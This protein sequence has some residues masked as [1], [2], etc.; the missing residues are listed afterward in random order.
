MR[1]LGLSL[2]IALALS[3][4]AWA[5][6]EIELLD[7]SKIQG[8][9]EKV[10]GGRIVITTRPEGSRLDIPLTY[11][12]PYQ[13][14]RA[15]VWG[16]KETDWTAHA[17]LADWCLRHF[18]MGGGDKE[19]LDPRLKQAA[20]T[21]FEQ[22]RQGGGPE[23]TLKEIAARHG[24]L[25]KDGKIVTPSEAGLVWDEAQQRWISPEEKAKL[26][27][28][29]AAELSKDL[30]K[31]KLIGNWDTYPRAFLPY[32][33]SMRT[34][35]KK[36]PKIR[37]WAK[38]EAKGVTF[39]SAVKTDAGPVDEAKYVR[40]ILRDEDTAVAFVDK[41]NKDLLQKI[42]AIQRGERVQVCGQVVNTEGG[43]VVLV[44]DL[45]VD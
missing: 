11:L 3:G 14:Y 44:A 42:D 34:Y 32:I 9:I 2:A 30:K 4:G 20:Q 26:D 6:E 17:T 22:A 41:S 36:F 8:S 45:V 27:A 12:S 33:G 15:R 1:T 39:G 24:F 16:Q 38:L 10:E 43:F 19:G 25:L 13:Q 29:R 18:N 23:D 21:E 31:R 5:Q 28:E 35:Y 40:L 37:F 7:G